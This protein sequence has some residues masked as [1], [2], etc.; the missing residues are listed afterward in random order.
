MPNELNKQANS[1]ATTVAIILL[2]AIIAIVLL[3]V[4]Y[5]DNARLSNNDISSIYDSGWHDGIN[6]CSEYWNLTD[7]ERMMINEYRMRV[8]NVTGGIR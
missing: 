8:Y 2:I 3:I 5:K 6:Q 7:A 1:I 4:S